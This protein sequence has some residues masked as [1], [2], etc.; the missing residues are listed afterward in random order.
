V[1]AA[2]HSFVIPEIAAQRHRYA[3]H[4]EKPRRHHPREDRGWVRI[5]RQAERCVI[6]SN[7]LLKNAV[8]AA[9]I[10]KIRRRRDISPVVVRPHHYQFFGMRHGQ[11]RQQRAVNHA[12]NRA[13]RADSQR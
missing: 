10:Q 1:F 13:A 9:P 3:L 6:P 2:W 4:G 8:V 5:S 11:G 12:E 7:Q